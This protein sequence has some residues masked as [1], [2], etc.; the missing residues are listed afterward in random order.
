MRIVMVTG[1]GST[2]PPPQGKKIVDGII[3]KPFDFASG[4]IDADR[5]ETRITRYLPQ[6]DKDQRAS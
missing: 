2:T 6:N 1:Y 5:F 4:R 3:G